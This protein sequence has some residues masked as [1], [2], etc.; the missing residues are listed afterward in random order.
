MRLRTACWL[1]QAMAGSGAVQ[2]RIHAHKE[3]RL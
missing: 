1:P 3:N 2:S